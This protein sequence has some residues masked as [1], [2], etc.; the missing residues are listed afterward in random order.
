M[1][2][3]DNEA[4]HADTSR[5]SKSGLDKIAKSPL[6]YWDAYL[7]PDRKKKEQTRALFLGSL[8]HCAIFEIAE[9]SKRY[10]VMPKFDMRTNKG[11]EGAAQWEVENAGKI[12]IVQDDYELSMRV[13]ES[14]YKHPAAAVLLEKGVAERVLHWEDQTTGAPCKLKLDFMSETGF[15]VDGKSTEDASADGFGR[16]AYNYRY[17]V[18]GAFYS[19]G[20]KEN[21]GI[22]S[23]G[24]AFIAY[25]KEPPYAVAVYFLTPEQ[26]ALGFAT[27]QKDLFVYA[28][29]RASN[30]WPAYGNEVSPLKFPAYAFK[31]FQTE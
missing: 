3:M 19:D 2:I 14:V 22:D 16:S 4:Y 13:R 9:F 7:N 5:I 18:Q 26:R 27:Y 10:A 24:F 12:G 30:V 20:Y 21:F 31:T 25:E 17:H 23:E 15:I 28:Q 29:C 6:H 8:T 1:I 11:K